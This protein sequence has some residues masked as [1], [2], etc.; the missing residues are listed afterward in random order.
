MLTYTHA[1]T[2]HPHALTYTRTHANTT[3]SHALAYTNAQTHAR[4][5]GRKCV[6]LL[7]TTQDDT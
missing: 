3:H 7:R 6:E 5:H 4:T 1:N 2:T